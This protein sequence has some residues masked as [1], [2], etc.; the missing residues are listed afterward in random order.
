M[1]HSGKLDDVYA[2]SLLQ[3]LL[4]GKP[5]LPMSGSSLRPL[6][7]VYI[8]NDIVINQR[9][10]IIEFGAGISTLLI[11]RLLKINNIAATVTSFDHNEPW[12]RV[13]KNALKKEGLAGKVNLVHAPLTPCEIALENN[14][15]YNTDVIKKHT[16]GKQ[17]DLMIVD[18]PPAYEPSIAT[19]RY[20]ALPY[21][22]EKLA[23][24]ASV[25]LDDASRHGEQ[26]ILEKWREAYPSIHFTLKG[27]TLAVAFRGESFFTDP[28]GYY[29]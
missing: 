7:L 26:I 29:P 1:S 2:L 16:H 14:A 13:L 21:L 3:P 27:D 22:A 4:A 17:Y 8:V 12:L 18:G 25:Y 15:W 24:R 10:H 23:E 5:F 9:R 11:A 20:P 19:S 28:F 6:C